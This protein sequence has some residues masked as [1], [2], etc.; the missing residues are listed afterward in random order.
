V[1][2]RTVDARVRDP[3]GR[4]LRQIGGQRPTQEGKGYRPPWWRSH[5]ARVIPRTPLWPVLAPVCAWLRVIRFRVPSS[6][7]FP[8]RPPVGKFPFATAR[9]RPASPTPASP[10][11][12]G[13]PFCACTRL[14][15]SAS[16]ATMTPV[17]IRDEPPTITLL[18]STS[19]IPEKAPSGT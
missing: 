11:D 14:L 13:W 4:R 5:H 15:G 18:I 6:S 19:R 7:S 17:R 2:A 9:T 12:A 1:V 3:V 10:K 8:Q 16:V